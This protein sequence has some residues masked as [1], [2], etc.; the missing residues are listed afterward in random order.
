MAADNWTGKI[1]V[2]DDSLQLAVVVLGDPAAENNSEFV[3]LTDRPIG[4]E[5]SFSHAI[6]GGTTRENHVV[7]KF[8]LRKKQPVIN[9]GPPAFTWSEKGDQLWE[10]FL[11]AALKIVGRQRIGE[12]L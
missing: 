6:Q 2:F 1:H 8:C 9:A 3:G 5:Q 4:I 11:T 10:P 12:S 7:A